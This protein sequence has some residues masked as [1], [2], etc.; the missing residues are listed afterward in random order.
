APQP[1]LLALDLELH[2]V[3]VPAVPRPG[4]PTAESCGVGGTELLAPQPDGLVADLHPALRQEFLHVAVAEREA[5]VQPHGVADDLGREA[6]ASIQ[7]VTGRRRRCGGGGGHHLILHGGA[8]QLV[9]AGH[10]GGALPASGAVVA[11]PPPRP[12]P[13]A[14]TGPAWS[15]RG[16]PPGG[17]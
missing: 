5:V 15:R 8:A 17:G 11:A 3:Q 10:D 9:N 1:V 2:L 7:R 14:P 12:A 13:A 4:A 16:A 6:I